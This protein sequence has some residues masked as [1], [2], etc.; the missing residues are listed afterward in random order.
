MGKRWGNALGGYRTQRRDAKGRFT[1]G[2]AAGSSKKHSHKKIASSKKKGLSGFQKTAIAGAVVAGTTAAGYAAYKIDAHNTLQE[3]N[4]LGGSLSTIHGKNGISIT[5]SREFKNRDLTNFDPVALNDFFESKTFGQA[6]KNGSKVYRPSLRAQIHATSYIHKGDELLGYTNE[7]VKGKRLYANDL[8][9][10]PSA[11]GIANRRVV[12]ATTDM[13]KQRHADQVARK[14][15]IV[16][17][18]YRSEDSERIVRNQQKRLGKS[19]V[20]VKERYKPSSDFTANIT[21]SLDFVFEK[22]MTN[23]FEKLMSGRKVGR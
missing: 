22:G 12:V 9:L 14:G 7:V 2:S 17:S 5:T 21:E 18:K 1:S 20:I 19:N 13:M 23:K 8:Y 10:K 15:K 4:R 3:F 11:R 16:I 6:L